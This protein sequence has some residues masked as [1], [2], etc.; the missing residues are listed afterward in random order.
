MVLSVFGERP[1]HPVAAEP[2]S[3]VTGEEEEL[4]PRARATSALPPQERKMKAG[5]KAGR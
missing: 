4:P 2:P 1:L 5:R 3:D